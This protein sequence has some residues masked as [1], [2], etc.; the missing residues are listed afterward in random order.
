MKETVK[1]ERETLA[2]FFIHRIRKAI[3]A[4]AGLLIFAVGVYIQMQCN[5]GMQP[6]Q[7]LRQGLAN[8]F[9]VTFGTASIVSSLVLITVDLLMRE[10]IGLGTF[11]DAFLVGIGVDICVFLDFLPVQTNLVVQVTMLLGSMV[12]CAVGQWLCMGAGLS[13]GPVDSFL[14]GVGKRLPKLTI[15]QTNRVILI[16]VLVGAFLLGSPLGLGTVITVFGTGF[17]MDFVFKF[18]GFKPREVVHEGLIDTARAFVQAVRG[19]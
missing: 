18:V 14:L 13:C 16:C 7:A 10:R 5:L 11:L 6:W 3:R 8:Q 9:G 4:S 2:Q 12:I 17:A 15:G 19:H 1:E